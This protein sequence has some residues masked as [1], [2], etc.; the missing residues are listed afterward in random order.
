MALDITK[1]TP[2]HEAIYDSKIVIMKKLE[3]A[4]DK[5]DGSNIHDILYIINEAR[6]TEDKNIINDVYSEISKSPENYS[7]IHEI[8]K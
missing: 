8:L 1:D 5:K 3:S 2:E 6:K 7:K 4:L